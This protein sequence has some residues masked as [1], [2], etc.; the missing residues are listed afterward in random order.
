[1]GR[2]VGPLATAALAA[3]LAA[4]GCTKKATCEEFPEAV[5]FTP[6][7]VVSDEVA[8]PDPAGPDA[9]QVVFGPTLGHAWAHGRG[10]VHHPIDKVYQALRDPGASRIKAPGE[11]WTAT[12]DTEPQFP[13][14]FGIHYTVYT[15][16]VTVEWDIQYRAGVAQG[17]E[18]APEVIGMRYQRT[19]GSSHISLESG[20][21]RAYP[22]ETDPSATKLE[23]VGWLVAD[24]Q[25]P[26][27]VGGTLEDWFGFLTAKLASL[28]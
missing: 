7:E 21:L 2:L 16:V 27:D 19:C 5:G 26:S 23:M 11:H 4:G 1:M 8:W 22:S 9:I 14:S 20:S 17:T 18:V 25:G 3:A 13:I 6:L 12:L 28:P 24:T 10:Y 15:S